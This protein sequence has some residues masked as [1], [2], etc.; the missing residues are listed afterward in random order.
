LELAMIE[1]TSVEVT[2]RD[3]YRLRIGFSDGESRE[4]ELAERLRSG[5]PVFRQL[6]DDPALFAQ[7]Y[8]DPDEAT[9]VWPNGADLAPE[10][11]HGDHYAASA[12][13]HR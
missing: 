9:T 4:I 5:G 10:V 6:Y 7:V 2:D 3:R 1:V 8:V 12:A 11:L 13:S